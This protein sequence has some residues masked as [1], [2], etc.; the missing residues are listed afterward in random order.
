MNKWNKLPNNAY[1]RGYVPEA[2]QGWFLISL[3]VWFFISQQ[4][5]GR[6]VIQHVWVVFPHISQI[7]P[8]H[9]PRKVC[10]QL[11][12]GLL[13]RWHPG[14]RTRSCKV[15]SGFKPEVCNGRWPLVNQPLIDF[16]L[17]SSSKHVTQ[18]PLHWLWTSKAS[19]SLKS[20]G[21]NERSCQPRSH[22]ESLYCCARGFHKVTLDQVEDE[23]FNLGE[24][25]DV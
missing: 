13:V 10:S 9:F 22:P 25:I 3:L 12:A 2:G 19:A 24:F 4:V 16:D 6:V 18:Q 7:I 1:C 17:S 5:R 20:F 11:F 8:Y 15:A 23:N 14:K 21:S